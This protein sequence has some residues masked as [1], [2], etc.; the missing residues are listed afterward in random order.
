MFNVVQRMTNDRALSEEIVQESFIKVFKNLKQF[1][2]NSTLGA[3]IKRIC[4]NTALNSL[5][6]RKINYDLPEEFPEPVEEQEV[7]LSIDVTLIHAEVKR[8]PQGSREI[9]C[10]YLLEGYKHK[11]IAEMLHISESTSRSQYMRGRKILKER[12]TPLKTMS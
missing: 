2:G 7:S 11:E 3:W 9:V 12:L 5:S 6:R 10:L 1:K 4:I 8:L